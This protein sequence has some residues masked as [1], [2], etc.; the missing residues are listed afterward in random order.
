MSKSKKVAVAPKMAYR[1]LH[2]RHTVLV[3]CADK[4]GKANIIT[5]AWTMPTSA[6][7]PMVAMSI[8]P[9]RLSY[10]MITETKEFVVNVPTMEI[11]KET[12]F[13]GRI[14]GTERDKFKGTHLTRMRAKK[15]HA[16]IIKQCVAHLE[17]KLVRKIKTGDHTLFVGQIIAAYANEGAFGKTLDIKKI[18][19]VYHMGGDDFTTV[20]S[21]V[22]SPP[23]PKKTKSTRSRGKTK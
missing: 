14:S 21:E 4:T 12:L 19:P 3:S 9:N 16:P 15:V 23:P 5:L 18:K 13:C 20:S 2:P 7:P 22:V 8:K 6:H 17:C 10:K 1:L 11:V